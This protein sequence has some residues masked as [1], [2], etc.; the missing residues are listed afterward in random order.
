MVF[1]VEARTGSEWIPVAVSRRASRAIAV[2]A[3]LEKT[4]VHPEYRVAVYQ[5][6][7][8]LPG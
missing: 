5:L 7:R 1:V 3:T 8:L 4:G 2:K 6:L